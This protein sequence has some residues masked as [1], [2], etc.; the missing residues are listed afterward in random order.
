LASLIVAIV[1]FF[2]TR[3]ESGGAGPFLSENAKNRTQFFGEKMKASIQSWSGFFSWF[4]FG[5][6][7][8]PQSV[9]KT[10]VIILRLEN[11]N[12]ELS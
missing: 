4:N 5:E 10:L 6:S 1:F 7:F 2:F 11:L 12:C 9:R 8:V 3:Y